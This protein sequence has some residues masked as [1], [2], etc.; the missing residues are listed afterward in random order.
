MKKL[1]NLIGKHVVGIMMFTMLIALLVLE[2]HFIWDHNKD[3][4]YQTSCYVFCWIIWYGIWKRG[5][6]AIRERNTLKIMCAAL[7]ATI[8]EK[9]TKEHNP[10]AKMPMWRKCKAGHAFKDDAIVVGLGEDKDPRLVKCA[11][12][13]SKYIL[14]KDLLKMLP[15]ELSLLS[16]EESKD[17]TK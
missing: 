2:F 3:G 8:G 14:V 16:E 13:D 4:I 12:N 1:I 5:D 10:D 11:I 9:D 17:A 6:K 15:N 7:M